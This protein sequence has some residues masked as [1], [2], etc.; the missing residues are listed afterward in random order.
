M[1]HKT[2]TRLTFAGLAL[3][4]VL[5]SFSALKLVGLGKG[6]QH[7][8]DTERVRSSKGSIM[9][10]I[11]QTATRIRD[12]ATAEIQTTRLT[13]EDGTLES[14]VDWLDRHGT[15]VEAFENS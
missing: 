3:L 10:V 14:V 13:L 11:T 5:L 8:I 12:G 15:A 2:S 6:I 1:Q 9:Q 7:L 4:F